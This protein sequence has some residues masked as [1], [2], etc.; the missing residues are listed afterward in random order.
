M[1]RLRIFLVFVLFSGLN[2]FL[3]YEVVKLKF[4]GF[5]L[6]IMFLS[7]NRLPLYYRDQNN[8]T[9]PFEQ[10]NLASK[11]KGLNCMCI[12]RLGAAS[13]NLSNVACILLNVSICSS[14]A[15]FSAVPS[16]MSKL[17]PVATSGPARIMHKMVVP[18]HWNTMHR[19]PCVYLK[20]LRKREP[21]LR[22]FE[23]VSWK[24]KCILVAV[25]ESFPCGYSWHSFCPFTKGAKSMTSSRLVSN[26]S[27]TRGEKFQ[28]CGTPQPLVW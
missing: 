11:M 15:T 5:K 9:E 3:Y 10:E 1:E 2:W 28:N 13:A 26:D 8:F 4:S 12:V 20:D 23:C 19:R 14:T 6:K 16:W 21:C 18:F 7:Q 24:E 27:L 22:K 25:G 17:N